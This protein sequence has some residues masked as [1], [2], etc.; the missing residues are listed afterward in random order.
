MRFCIVPCKP[1]SRVS[2]FTLIE[3]M[4]TMAIVAILAGIALPAYTGY[5]ARAHRADARTQLVQAAQFMQRF[6]A[7]NDRFD[8]DRAGN[9]VV[10]DPATNEVNPLIFGNLKHS[11]AD[12]TK[13]YDL[14]IPPAALPLTNAMSF[15]L[16]MVPVAG[17]KMANDECG[18]FTLTSLGVR[19]V[20]V[21]ET[22]D[23]GD[24]RNKCW[25]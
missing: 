6:Y 5:I 24:L 20:R 11:P 9:K 1:V 8:K 10:I 14:T 15:T 25:K 7:A 2:G 19:G 4:I 13:L 22:D 12:G 18:T 21:N 17:G 23:T 16:R 3:L